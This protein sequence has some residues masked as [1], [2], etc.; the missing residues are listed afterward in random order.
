MPSTFS[1]T[2][3]AD[4][5]VLS[6]E[7]VS[8]LT[9]N[10]SRGSRPHAPA[11]QDVHSMSDGLHVE[12]VRAQ[13]TATKVIEHFGRLQRP[14][15]LFVSHAVRAACPTPHVY[16][17]VTVAALGAYPD[18]AVPRESNAV[19]VHR[20]RV[21][22]GRSARLAAMSACQILRPS[23]VRRSAGYRLRHF[24]G[25]RAF[26]QAL[27]IGRRYPGGMSRPLWRRLRW[28]SVSGF[29]ILQ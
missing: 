22:A 17:A 25:Q 10:L 2:T 6:R 12:R 24:C 20:D 4:P 7:R 5:Q 14:E 1:C 21:I 9:S 18:P 8:V 26:S 11:A 27:Q 15:E 28:N 29:A 16:T 23:V 13:S 3:L 19:P